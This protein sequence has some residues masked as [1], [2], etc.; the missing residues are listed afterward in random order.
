MVGQRKYP[1]WIIT[2]EVSI[3]QLFQINLKPQSGKRDLPVRHSRPLSGLPAQHSAYAKKGKWTGDWTNVTEFLTSCISHGGKSQS[4][5]SAGWTRKSRK[6]R[7][8]WKWGNNMSLQRTISR[9]KKRLGWSEN[10][11]SRIDWEARRF[12]KAK[13]DKKA[14]A[15]KKARYASWNTQSHQSIK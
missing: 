7:I 8:Y 10:K 2:H 3:W 4:T 5:L 12:L 11:W 1:I 6:S 14:R 15:E 13:A 9:S